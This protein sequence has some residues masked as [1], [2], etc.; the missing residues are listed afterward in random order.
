MHR[1]G[2]KNQPGEELSRILNH[3][4]NSTNLNDFLPVFIILQIDRAQEVEN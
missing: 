3:S 2:I 1:A 4:D